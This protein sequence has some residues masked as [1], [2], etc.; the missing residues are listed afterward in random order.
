MYQTYPAKRD[1]FPPVIFWL[2]LINAV[3]YVVPRTVG[4]PR[5]LLL[6]LPLFSNMEL[7]RPWQLMTYAFLHADVMHFAFNM[8]ALWMFGRSIEY[9][10][11]SRRFALYYLACVVGAAVTQLLA[12][13]F[14]SGLGPP[15]IGASGGVFGVLLAFGMLFP[16]QRIMLLFPPIP[17]PAKYFV[18]IY[19]A[20]ELYLGVTRPG[21]SIAHFAHLGGL[22]AGLLLILYWRSKRQIR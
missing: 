8:L 13:G 14:P 15:T 16:N 21:S 1:T 10:W 11:G 12:T 4:L 22:V 20:L 2:L 17:L 19:A 6:A 7:F 18:I 3:L 5:E 9:T